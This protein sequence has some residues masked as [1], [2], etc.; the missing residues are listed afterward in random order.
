MLQRDSGRDSAARFSTSSREGAIFH[1]PLMP[2]FGSLVGYV[3]WGGLRRGAGL[4]A[5]Q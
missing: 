5:R 2:G 1:E 4:A 3:P